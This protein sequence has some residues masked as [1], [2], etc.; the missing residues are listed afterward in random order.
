MIIVNYFSETIQ[1][2]LLTIDVKMKQ[3]ILIQQSSANLVDCIIIKYQLVFA[4]K[5]NKSLLIYSED[6]SFIRSIKL[7]RAPRSLSVI[8]DI[9]VAISYSQH[10]IEI[11]G[12]ATG[13]VNRKIQTGGKTFG[14]SFIDEL[15]Y[16]LIDNKNIEVMKLTNEKIKSFP[17]HKSSNR[18]ITTNEDRLFLTGCR[19]DSVFCCDLNGTFMWEFKNKKMKL[20]DGLT[21]DGNGNTYVTGYHTDN[22]VVISPDGK[23]HKE[24]LTVKNGLRKPT[25]IYY[26]RLSNWLLVCNKWNGHAF[27][28][29]VKDSIE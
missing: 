29:T 24:L 22:V 17:C 23:N 7:S 9:D 4:D 8:N 21:T 26:D 11:L 19:T 6:G 20:P 1:N 3:T 13:Q 18:S 2:A 12:I 16:V 27:L 25:G 10:Y 15:L 14:L 28:Y 5:Y